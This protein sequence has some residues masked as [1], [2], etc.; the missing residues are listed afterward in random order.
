VV[1]Y[2][3]LVRVRGG[4][5]DFLSLSWRGALFLV[6]ESILKKFVGFSSPRGFPEIIFESILFL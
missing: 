4:S 6:G 1:H 5:S 3:F 2:P